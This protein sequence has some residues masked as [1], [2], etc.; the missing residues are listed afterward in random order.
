MVGPST[1]EAG[2][3]SS[4]VLQAGA[5]WR[6]L[7]RAFKIHITILGVQKQQYMAPRLGF[8]QAMVYGPI[9]PCEV[10]TLGKIYNPDPGPLALS[11]DSKY[12]LL[13][14][15]PYAPIVYHIPNKGPYVKP[16]QK[17]DVRE[18]AEIRDPYFEL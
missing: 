18:G 17:K 15:N 2:L 3:W 13:I 10:S 5:S 16:H 9:G 11:M 7:K 4:R 1:D 12:G 8:K 14:W 6:S